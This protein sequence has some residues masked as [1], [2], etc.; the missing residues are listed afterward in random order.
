MGFI[1]ISVHFLILAVFVR[2]SITAKLAKPLITLSTQ[3]NVNEAD[4]LKTQIVQIGT[5]SGG[6]TIGI[7]VKRRSENRKSR[8][9]E[10]P[11]LEIIGIRI[12]DEPDD[13]TNV[14]RNAKIVNNKLIKNDIEISRSEMQNQKTTA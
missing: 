12:P 7:I 1:K 4:P 2:L 8:E 3:I 5:G 11:I 13:Q 14:Y 6:G 9:V 10:D